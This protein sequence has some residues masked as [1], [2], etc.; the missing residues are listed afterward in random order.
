VNRGLNQDDS[1]PLILEL[2]C[3]GEQ[4]FRQQ[5]QLDLDVPVEKQ[6][7]PLCVPVGHALPATIDQRLAELGENE[8]GWILYSPLDAVNWT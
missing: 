8:Y 6:P 2:A 5:E 1:F 4:L 3:R 7:D